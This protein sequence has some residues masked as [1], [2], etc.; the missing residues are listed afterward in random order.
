MFSLQ[1]KLKE[2]S[3][4]IFGL[5]LIFHNFAIPIR[6]SVATIQ[7][8]EEEAEAYADVPAVLDYTTGFY[9]FPVCHVISPQIYA[10]SHHL[11][12]YPSQPYPTLSSLVSIL[13]DIHTY[14]VTRMSQSR[15]LGH[16]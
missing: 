8:S 16:I 10:R 15:L 9:V 5:A 3:N 13:P 7:L 12:N 1:G 4:R 14:K 2:T 6:Q 11:R